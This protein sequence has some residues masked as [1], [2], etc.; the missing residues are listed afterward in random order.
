MN[1]YFAPDSWYEQDIEIDHVCDGCCQTEVMLDTIKE[2]MNAIILMLY[3][4][5]ALDVAKFEDHIA[6]ICTELRIKL[7]AELPNIRR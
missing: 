5:N 4:N 3:S 2:E 7:P 1:D 6:E